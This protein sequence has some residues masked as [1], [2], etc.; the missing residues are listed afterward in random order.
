MRK[1][2]ASRD[3]HRYAQET[4]LI[5][6]ESYTPK[7]DYSHH[8]I[9]PISSSSMFRL[10]S[11][12]RGA[13]GFVE[14]AH[15]A[16][17]FKVHSKAPVY[18]YDRLGEPNKDLLE[19]NLAIAERSD[20]AVTF[21]SGMAAISALCG[22]L[23]GS[24]S[25]V[26]AHRTLYGCT[27]S[28]FT[29]WLP[30]YRVKVTWVDFT[31]LKEVER[32]ITPH[33]RLLYFES[34]VNP[35]LELIDMG[36]VA[37]IARK[38]NRH[39]KPEHRIHT[40]VDN[41]F[42]TPFCQRPVEFGIDFVVASLTKGICGFGTDV[43][44]MVA[45]PEW[46]YDQLLMYRKDFGGI[47]SAKSAWPI[48][49][50]GLPSLAVRFRQ[51]M[52]NAMTVASALERD[53]R[54]RFV[55]YPGLDTFRQRSLAHVQLHDYE[56][57]FAPGTMVYFTLTGDTAA[58]RHE[59][60]RRMVD[61]IGENSY[62]MTLAVSLGSIRSLIEHPGSMTHS[63]IPP[64]EQEKGGLDPGGIRLSVGL[65]NP[66]DVIHDLREALDHIRKPR[67]KP[68]NGEHRGVRRR[69]SRTRKA[70]PS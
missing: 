5:W 29:N 61:S 54:I 51:Q 45:G 67:Q 53:P 68:T 64:E 31:D 19:E 55:N 30:R 12:K 42:A 28:L 8:V 3:G 22:I 56:G 70:V 38:H 23:L 66:D 57:R 10:D 15:H 65:E 17:D 37:E 50:Y 20:C 11:S 24:G 26:V 14:F 60:A 47:L 58:E 25:E 34:P 40:A 62:S 13:Q 21:A 32:A 52:Q 6:G 7:W 18:I 36:A 41:T 27:Y 46:S 48:L 9:P 69:A 49:V 1:R 16:E 33:T 63:S 2:T 39:R 43:G 59:N 4:K 44:G 35:T